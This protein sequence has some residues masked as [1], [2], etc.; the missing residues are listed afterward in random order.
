MAT[1]ECD[2]DYLRCVIN[3]NIRFRKCPQCDNEGMSLIAYNSDGDPCSSQEPDA[4][5]SECEA[6]DGV[7]FIEI[8]DLA[9]IVE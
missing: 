3:G 4:S 1:I 8:P 5:K 9:Q 2:S 7:A 6:C